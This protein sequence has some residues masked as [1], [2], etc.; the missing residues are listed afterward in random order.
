MIAYCLS[1]FKGAVSGH[2]C[3]F[4]E[5]EAAYGAAWKNIFGSNGYFHAAKDIS[6]LSEEIDAAAKGFDLLFDLKMVFKLKKKYLILLAPTRIK[7]L[8]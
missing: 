3:A 2:F 5:A 1:Y 7:Y 8:S 6:L 4:G